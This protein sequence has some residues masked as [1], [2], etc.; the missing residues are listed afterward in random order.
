MTIYADPVFAPLD[1]D[2]NMERVAGGNETEVYCTDNRRYV[3]KIK[4]DLG[5][6]LDTALQH[7]QAMRKAAE[8]FADCLSQRY[9]IP[10]Y[11]VISRDGR[12]RAQVLVIQPFIE[13][14]RALYLVD[15]SALSVEERA[16]LGAHLREII[17]R[18]LTFY[19]ASGA[20]PDLYGRSSSSNDERTRMNTLYML[21]W[22]LWSFLI[23]RN[24]LRSH[25]LLLTEAPEHQVMLIDYDPVRRS[26]LYRSIYY[27]VRWMLFWRDQILIK[28]MERG[29]KVPPAS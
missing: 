18:S 19:K 9:S 25:N 17:R 6:D 4:G 28:I 11:Y 15:Y 2:L 7:A 14:A 29:G 21:P 23:Q 16:Q 1:R 12:G 26:R 5:G 27:A 20:M 3:V 8:Q 13:R 10:S 22:R 24:L